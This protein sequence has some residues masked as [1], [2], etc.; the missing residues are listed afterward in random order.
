MEIDTSKK[1]CTTCKQPYTQRGWC[2]PCEAKR[3]KDNFQNWTSGNNEL[4]QFIRNTQT[5]TSV[6][7][8]FLE[9]IPF[10]KFEKITEI[11]KGGFGVVYKATWDLGPKTFWDDNRKT[12]IREGEKLIALKRIYDSRN[13]DPHFWKEVS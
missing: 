11:G 2:Q 5:N 4:D 10:D 13:A 1:N 3:F 9:W 8:M 6:P 12:W 7:L